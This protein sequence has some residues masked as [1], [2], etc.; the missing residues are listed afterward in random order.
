MAKPSG[1]GVAT[2]N[3]RLGRAF[4]RGEAREF[5]GLRHKA[6]QIGPKFCLEVRILASERTTNDDSIGMIFLD[7]CR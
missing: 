6:A 7:E 1:V 4:G 2:V 3:N 5:S